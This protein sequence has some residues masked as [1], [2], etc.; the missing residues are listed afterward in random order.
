MVECLLWHYAE[1]QCT[2]LNLEVLYQ[3]KNANDHVIFQ[4]IVIY[5][6]VQVFS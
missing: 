1:K 3:K 2:H 5:M 4:Y 6:P